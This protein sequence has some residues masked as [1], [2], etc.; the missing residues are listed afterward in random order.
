MLSQHIKKYLRQLQQKKFRNEYGEFLVEGIKGVA[1]ALASAYALSMIVFEEAKKDD[2]PIKAI[3]KEAE[4][5]SVPILFCGNKDIA[6]IKTTETF[7]GVL[8]VIKQ[9]NIAKEDLS[10][11]PILCLDGIQDPGN[12]GTIIRTADWFGIRNM[13]L[14]HDCVDAYNP[15]VVRSTMGS[16]FRTAVYESPAVLSDLLFFKEQGYAVIGFDA[17]GKNTLSDIVPSDKIVYVFGSESHG[18]RDELL[19]LCDGTYRIPGENTAESLNVGVAVGIV[20]YEI[21]KK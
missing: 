2:A 10:H 4:K 5:R 3:M 17:S 12:L 9:K 21:A 6:G 8:A 16:L 14:S 13:V 20:L 19:S 1:E 15:K 7:P 11:G 18:I